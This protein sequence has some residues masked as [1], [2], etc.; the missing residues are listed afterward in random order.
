M[1][2]ALNR[3]WTMAS[4]PEGEPTAENFE[5]VESTIPT[6]KH[7]EVLIRTRYMSLDPYMRGRMRSGPSYATPLQPGDVMTG[8]VVAL[9]EKSESPL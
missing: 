5:I 1:S 6:P 4:R 3:A 7:G 2:K 9:V 8:E